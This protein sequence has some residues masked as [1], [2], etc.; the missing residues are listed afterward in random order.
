[1]SD[2]TNSY[3]LLEPRQLRELEKALAISQNVNVSGVP[4]NASGVLPRPGTDISSLHCASMTYFTAARASLARCTVAVTLATATA[5]AGGDLTQN[6][7]YP[8]GLGIHCPHNAVC[9]VEVVENG[10]P[11]AGVEF[12]WNRSIYRARKAAKEYGS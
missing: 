5:T 3:P 1:M 7:S 4:D 2:R 10:E 8:V 12:T 6:V 11:E 9:G